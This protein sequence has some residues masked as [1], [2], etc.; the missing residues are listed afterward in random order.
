M[1][2]EF[3]CGKCGA[4]VPEDADSCPVCS[5]PKPKSEA[6]PVLLVLGLLCS[7]LLMV[8]TSVVNVATVTKSNRP[9][10]TGA[11]EMNFA[12]YNAA[13]DF[14]QQRN[15]N[16]KNFSEFNRSPIE[17]SDHS[18]TVTLQTDELGSDN[19]AIRSFY[20]VELESSDSGWKLKGIRQ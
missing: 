15:P 17:H 5:P 16:V 19:Q 20:R 8:G 7:S 9:A 3:I 10:Q 18:Y 2:R 4:P 12:A 6:A 1:T 14:V 11:T 13:K